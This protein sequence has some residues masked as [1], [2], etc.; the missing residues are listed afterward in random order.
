MNMTLDLVDALGLEA[1]E[2]PAVDFVL[3]NGISSLEDICTVNGLLLRNDG[4][5]V[6][7][8]RDFNPG[9]IHHAPHGEIERLM[10][11]LVDAYDVLTSFQ[12]HDLVLRIHPFIDKNGGTARLVW[13]DKEMKL[14][15]RIKEGIYRSFY[16]YV[17]SP[18]FYPLSSYEV[19]ECL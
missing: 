18:A 11:E 12:A 19:K 8:I 14:K 3:K 16:M 6:Y 7:R 1:Y 9:Y 13:F 17:G 4:V 10:R 15:G 5:G 2:Q